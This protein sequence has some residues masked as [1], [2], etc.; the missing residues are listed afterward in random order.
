MS[1]L[2]LVVAIHFLIGGIC[3]LAVNRKLSREAGKQNWLKF[4]FYLLIYAIVLFSVLVNRNVF[5]GVSM[6]IFSGSI[7]ELMKLGKQASASASRFH[8]TFLSLSLFSFVASLFSVFIFLQSGFILYVYT[9]VII[10]DGASQISG[11]LAGKRKILPRLSPNKTLEGL[12]GGMLSAMITSLIL[13]KLGNLTILQSLL[14]GLIIC[15][16]SF[17]GDIAA[18]GYKRAFNAKDFGNILPGQGGVLDRFDSFLVTGA[19]IGGLSLFSVFPL[20]LQNMNMVAYLAYSIIFMIILLMGEILHVVIKLKAEYSRMFSHIFTGIASLFF[21]KFFSDQWYVIALCIQSSL[22]IYITKKFEL[23]SSHHN[24]ERITNG[25][26]LFFIGILFAY[27]ISLYKNDSS[28]YL[29]AVSILSLSDPAASL[30]GLNRKKGFLPK[31]SASASAKTYMGSIGF[32]SIAFIILIVGLSH[33]YRLA[34]ILLIS[35]STLIALLATTMEA[36]SSKGTDNLTVPIAVSL[37][38]SLFM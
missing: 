5:M 13:H 24:V 6:L 21:V 1:L 27:L 17:I 34:P 15:F 25:S 14:T 18:S 37:L 11:Q 16:A 19:L 20:D 30:L 10:F 7:L 12:I 22:F 8:I 28:I 26:S 9:I 29:I 36:I 33:F 32:F 3:T 23:L 38:L 31:V 4:V 2:I 35:Y